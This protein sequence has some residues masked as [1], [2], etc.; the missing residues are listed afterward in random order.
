MEV[1]TAIS[2]FNSSYITKTTQNIGIPPYFKI[3]TLGYYIHADNVSR[4]TFLKY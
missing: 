3:K 1:R 4:E 2:L